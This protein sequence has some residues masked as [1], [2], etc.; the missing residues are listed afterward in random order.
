MLLRDLYWL[1]GLL[2]GEGCFC[3]QCSPGIKLGMTDKDVVE[4]VAKLFGRHT[5]GP[6]KYKANKK[7]VYY[8]EVWGA[9]AI[10]LME[11][12]FP[13]MGHRRAMK[14]NEIWERWQKA[15]GKG[16]K[17]GTGARPTCHPK[18]KHYAFGMCRSCYRKD[19]YKNGLS[20]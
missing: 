2:E 16:H 7:P 1:A 14:I 5:R 10:S 20:R 12:V 4:R 8:T 19:K 17:L 3:Y 18:L 11:K 9:E 6:Y 15:P 13:H